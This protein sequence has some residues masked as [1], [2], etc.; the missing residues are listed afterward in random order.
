M[1][2][3]KTYVPTPHVVKGIHLL[4]VSQYSGL[5]SDKTE[6]LI[7]DRGSRNLSVL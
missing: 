6:F 4:F 1:F 5:E 3:K 7:Q 2:V